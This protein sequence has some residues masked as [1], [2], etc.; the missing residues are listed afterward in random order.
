MRTAARRASDALARRPGTSALYR[1]R[2]QPVA[3]AVALLA[4]VAPSSAAVPE[5]RCAP[6]SC[7]LQYRVGH[8][9]AFADTGLTLGGFVTAEATKEEGEPGTVELDSVNFLLFFEPRPWIEFVTELELGGLFAADTDRWDV[10][11]NPELELERAYVE[12]RRDDALRAQLGKFLMPIGRWNLVRAEPLTWTTSEPLLT[13]RAYDEDVSGALVAGR[14]FGPLG[15]LD[16]SVYG[17]FVDPI[18]PA[19]EEGDLEPADRSAGARLQLTEGAGLW[20][21]GTSFLAAER[22]GNWQLLGG[23]DAELQ[24][25]ARLEISAEALIARGDIA[26]RDLWGAY[27]QAAYEVL[28]SVHAVARC[29]Y[30]HPFGPEPD[31]ALLDLGFAWD[32]WAF[33]RIKADYRLVS[34]RTDDAAPGLSSSISLLF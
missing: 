4:W 20:S 19:T 30:H 22:A 18:A 5:E 8:G 16:Y 1:A 29:E 34:E 11:S 28:P 9:L 21:I 6:D 10:D 15:M 32:P 25:C 17:Q 2:V 7:A 26:E 12:L 27:V 24:A 3:A 33:L 31:V 14:L 23:V 13:E